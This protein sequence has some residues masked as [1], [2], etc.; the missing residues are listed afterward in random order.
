[1]SRFL[2]VSA[3]VVV[4]AGC[5]RPC[6]TSAQCD[7]GRACNGE[8]ACVNDVCVDGTPPL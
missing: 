3:V 5:A 8:E 4:L 1:M 6:K 2:S 7:D